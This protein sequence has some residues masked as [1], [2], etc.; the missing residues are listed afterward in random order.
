MD[1]EA[2]KL[3]AYLKSNSAGGVHCV[4]GLKLEAWFLKLLLGI[5]HSD[6]E[7]VAPV[8]LYW[9]RLLFG[10]E[11]FAERCGLYVRDS[12]FTT[13]SADLFDA[14]LMRDSEVFGIAV[15][16]AGLNFALS[17]TQ[18]FAETASGTY[19]PSGMQIGEPERARLAFK[20]PEYTGRHLVV[21]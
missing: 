2:G 4:D 20:W 15:R 12:H 19:R 11:L 16:I 1:T 13:E 18:P 14:S 8:P 21:S 7:L 6:S 9:L 5:V 17:V 10:Q 3:F